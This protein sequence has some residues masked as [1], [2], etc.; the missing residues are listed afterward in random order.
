MGPG[1]GHFLAAAAQ[2]GMS[3][4]GVETSPA[5]RRIISEVW[6]LPVHES[7]IEA[8]QL[9][10]EQ[11][12]NVVSFNCLE[13]IPDVAGHFRAVKRLLAPGGRFFVSTCNAGCL[14]ALIAGKWW[15]MY[16]PPDHVSIPTFDSMRQAGERSALRLAKIW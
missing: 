12:D 5:H 2:A 11:Y 9:P 7:P 4:L 13:H 6:K 3:V 1:T 8:N 10:A 15:S 14:V 16:A